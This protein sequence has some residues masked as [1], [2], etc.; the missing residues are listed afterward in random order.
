MK[1]KGFACMNNSRF[2]NAVL[3]IYYLYLVKYMS[4]NSKYIQLQI[5]NPLFFIVWTHPFS[6]G[7]YTVIHNLYMFY[8]IIV[9]WLSKIKV[10]DS[11]DLEK[12]KINSLWFL[13]ITSDYYIDKAWYDKGNDWHRYIKAWYSVLM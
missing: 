9:L 1:I 3:V 2:E 5:L 10:F 12:Q 8:Y 7:C 13:K 6:K 4:Y 11:D